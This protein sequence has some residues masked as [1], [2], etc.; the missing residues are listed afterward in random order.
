MTP[1]STAL[2]GRTAC[3]AIKTKKGQ[4]LNLTSS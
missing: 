2:T 4:A 3:L 1:Q